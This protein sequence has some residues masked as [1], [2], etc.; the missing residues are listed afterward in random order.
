MVQISVFSYFSGINGP[1]GSEFIQQYF[2]N[3]IN[4][5]VP[6][7]NLR[8]GGHDSNILCLQFLKVNNPFGPLNGIKPLTLSIQIMQKPDNWNFSLMQV[9][10]LKQLAQD[11]QGH[12]GLNIPLDSFIPTLGHVCDE[13]HILDEIEP[14]GFVLLLA[15]LV[16]VGESSFFGNVLVDCSLGVHDAILYRQV[17]LIQGTVCLYPQLFYEMVQHFYLVLGVHSTVADAE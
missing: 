8:R 2:K 13:V 12:H 11:F 14:G 4:G 7:L 3:F 6:W 1:K 5:W 10:I 15:D 16:V 9:L 17:Y